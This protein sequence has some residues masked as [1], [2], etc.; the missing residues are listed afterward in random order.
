MRSRSTD[1]ARPAHGGTRLVNPLPLDYRPAA[2]EDL[3]LVPT[4]LRPAVLEHLTRIAADYAS[5][6]RLSSFPRPPC[7][8]SGLWCQDPDGRASL[9]EVLFH[10]DI[11]PERIIVRRVLLRHLERL[12][13]WVVNSAEWTGEPPWPVV[14]I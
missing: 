10:I 3:R 11:T 12:P 4:E 6:S 2:V 5:C 8:E 14:Q 7:V 13:G 9:L 1:F